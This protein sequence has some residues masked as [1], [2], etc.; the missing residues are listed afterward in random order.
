[1][2]LTN[3]RSLTRPAKD[4]WGVYD[5]QQA[6]IAALVAR[7][8]ARDPKTAAAVSTPATKKETPESPTAPQRP[9]LADAQ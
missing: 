2:A 7:L 6:G 1:M 3:T 8:D 9:T 4:E 5:P